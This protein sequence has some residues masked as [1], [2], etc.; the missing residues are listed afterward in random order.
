MLSLI[1]HWEDQPRFHYKFPCMMHGSRIPLTV[2]INKNKCIVR[3]QFLYFWIYLYSPWVKVHF[4]LYTHI[5]NGVKNFCQ[6]LFNNPWFFFRSHHGVGFT[7][8]SDHKQ[9]LYL[10]I[11]KNTLQLEIWKEQII[12]ATCCVTQ[13]VVA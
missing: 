10:E 1:C 11:E 13:S 9:I 8:L 12:H 3:Y 4:N 5:F 6:C 2:S 7:S